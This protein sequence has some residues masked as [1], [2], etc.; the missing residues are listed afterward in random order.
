MIGLVLGLDGGGSKTFAATAD[1]SGRIVAAVAGAGIDPTT[2]PD[3]EEG[4]AAL[5]APLGPVDAAVLGLPFHGEIPA[6]SARQVAVAKALAGPQA[7]V[8]NDVAVA[9]SGALAGQDGVLILA[10][11]GSMAWARGPQGEVRCGGWGN[12]FGDEGSAFWIGRE[13]LALVS[14]H[15]DGRQNAPAFA[16][17]LLARLH[18]D[19]AGLIGWVYDQP[20]QRA[21]IASVAVHVSGLAAA[22]EGHAQ[23]LLDRAAGHLAD[24][25]LAAGKAG[26]AALPLCWSYAGGVF[27]NEYLRDRVAS[28]LAGPPIP[29]R[30]PPLGGGLLLAARAAGWPIDSAFLSRLATS[31]RQSTL[32]LAPFGEQSEDTH[33]PPSSMQ[34]LERRPNAN[35]H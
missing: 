33:L 3:W 15:L 5:I 18:L 34:T 9:F 31:L 30:L 25:G 1:P 4:L 35:D 8:L 7:R 28:R 24:L 12:A 19:A 22:G 21:R 26:G 20:L 17:G 13:A 2:G 14:Q 11:T 27:Q 23:T 29:P 16:T 6:I 10:G 32:P